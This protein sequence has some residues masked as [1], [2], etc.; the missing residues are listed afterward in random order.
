[1]GETSA[2]IFQGKMMATGPCEACLKV[3]LLQAEKG[4]NMVMGVWLRKRDFIC[5][6][7]A[8]G[9]AK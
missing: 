2:D 7:I 6:F 1:M 9:F 5:N 4:V 3:Y 8:A